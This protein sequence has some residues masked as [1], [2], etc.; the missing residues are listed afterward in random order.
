MAVL[1]LSR[2]WQQCQP[3]AVVL[4]VCS[5][6][7]FGVSGCKK[8]PLEVM[9]KIECRSPNGM[10]QSHRLFEWKYDRVREVILSVLP[11]GEQGMEFKEL[12]STAEK[13][14][15]ASEKESIGKIPWFIETV[16]LEMETRGELQRFPDTETSLPMNVRLVKSQP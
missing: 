10:R 1:G 3:L 13:K 5:G 6:T 8:P 7:L 14:F 12:R 15:K 4:L 2:G 16:A 11:E 9:P